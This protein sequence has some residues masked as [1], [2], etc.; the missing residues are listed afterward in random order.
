[1]RKTERMMTMPALSVMMKPSSGMCNM[2]C[3]YCFYCDEMVKRQQQLYGFMSEET[4]KNII[5]KTMFQ[6]EHQIT[7][8][9]QGGEPT[10]RGIDFFRKAVELQKKYN[11]N[12]LQ[13][14]NALQTNGYALNEEWCKFFKENDFLIGVSVDG[15]KEIH[16]TYRRS[17]G[18]GEPTYDVIMRHIELLDKYQVD[19]NILTVVTEKT[20]HHAKEIYEYYRK[21]GWNFQQYIECMD[22]LGAE[23]PTEYSLK[24]ETLGHFLTELF[25]LWYQDY[26]RG[27]Q[28]Y[29]RKFE[30]YI[31][32]LVGCRSEACDQRGECGI[33]LV[34]EADGSAYPCD[35]FMLDDYKLGNF[36]EDRLPQMNQRRKEIGFVERSR[37]I[38]QECRAC[39]YYRVC[40]SGCQRTRDFFPEQ[41]AYKSHYCE[42]YRYF[43]DHCLDRM[44]KIAK[45]VRERM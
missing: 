30:N 27:K 44:M 15:T 16:D 28:P 1:M 18:K 40:R 6:A 7:Y 34:V 22:P 11:H 9:Y 29:I 43:F 39:P 21:M 42:G 45:E 31:G 38:T 37:K 35:F 4:L 2:H 26:L 41:D 33:Q 23:E 20:A 14:F 36:N 25:D 24:P 8:A 12:H 5:H 13:V 19:Y 17:A 10:L 3:Q 32:I